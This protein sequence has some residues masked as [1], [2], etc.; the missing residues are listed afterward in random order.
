MNFI[1]TATNKEGRTIHG[2]LEAASKESAILSLKHQGVRPIVLK[3][4]STKNA[5]RKRGGFGKRVSLK[6]LVVFTRQL[7][8]MVSAGVPLNRS[9]STLQTETE[10][11]YF[12]EVIGS[13]SKD[14]QAGQPLGEAFGKFPNVFSDVYV[15]MVRAGEAGGILDEILKR[16]A[17]QI[18]KESSMHKK[19]RSAMTYPVVILSVTTVAFFGI[20]VFIIPKINKIVKDLAGPNTQLPIYTRILLGVSDFMRHNALFIIVGVAITSYLLGKYIRTPRGKYQFHGLLLRGPG[21]K[22]LKLS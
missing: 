5:G 19:I 4:T 14:I 6:D 3:V 15:N 2:T 9:L 16:L 10:N 8:T 22:S 17:S 7:S 11:K 21:V 1:Y 13:V 12:K 20:M 18:E